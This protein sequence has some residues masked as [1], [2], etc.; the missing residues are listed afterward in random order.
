MTT[1][2]REDGPVAGDRHALDEVELEQLRQRLIRDQT[3]WS[4]QDIADA[5]GVKYVTVLKWRR[6]AEADG[7]KGPGAFIA[8][9]P[10]APGEATDRPRWRAG[11]VRRWAMQNGR[12]HPDGQPCAPRLPGRATR[13]D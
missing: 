9:E 2:A 5:L 4:M 11:R 1:M 13:T 6:R 3:R 7:G 8:P 10:P 12:M